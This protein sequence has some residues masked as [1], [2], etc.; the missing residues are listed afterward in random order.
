MGEITADG[1][2]SLEFV[3]CIGACDIAPA[4]RINDKVFGDLIINLNLAFNT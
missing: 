2:F 1:N 3:S 4:V